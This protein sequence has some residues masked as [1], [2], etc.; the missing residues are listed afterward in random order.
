MVWKI[1]IIFFHFIYCR[2]SFIFWDTD[3][4]RLHYGPTTKTIRWKKRNK[5]LKTQTLSLTIFF[6]T[7]EVFGFPISCDVFKF[8]AILYLLFSFQIFQNTEHC[9]LN[10]FTLP[11]FGI[12][13]IFFLLISLYL[14]F[15]SFEEIFIIIFLKVARIQPRSTIVNSKLNSLHFS[16]DSLLLCRS[17]SFLFGFGGEIFYLSVV[18]RTH[19]QVFVDCVRWVVGMVIVL[20]LFCFGSYDILR[21]VVSF[22]YNFRTMD[23]PLCELVMILKWF[24]NFTPFSNSDF[25]RY[26]IVVL[27]HLR[28]L[29]LV[30][31][32]CLSSLVISLFYM[33]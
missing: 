11:I 20:G 23:V 19:T 2:H 15:F 4:H 8:F 26:C 10:T 16:F 28:Y 5:R 27:R 25:K 24:Y 17:G 31:K 32:Y 14:Y 1:P 18:K 22:F 30:F 9:T 13:F 12:L 3:K 7:Y 29:F 33:T 6:F 21:N